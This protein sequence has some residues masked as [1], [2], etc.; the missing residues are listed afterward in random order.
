MANAPT[1]EFQKLWTDQIEC[2][3]LECQ[4]AIQKYPDAAG[5]MERVHRVL[6]DIT[7]LAGRTPNSVG[8][9]SKWNEIVETAAEESRNFLQ[10]FFGRPLYSALRGVYAMVL[11]DLKGVLQESAAKSD[12]PCTSVVGTEENEFCEIKKRKRSYSGSTKN[13]PK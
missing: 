4:D 11:N 5:V 9:S 7:N 8:Q 1:P 10:L 13:E 3:M 12:A 6:V 2:L